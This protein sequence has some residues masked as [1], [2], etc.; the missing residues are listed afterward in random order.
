MLC[1]YLFVVKYIFIFRIVATVFAL[2]YILV[3][4]FAKFKKIEVRLLILL[5]LIL[6]L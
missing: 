3:R 2:Y 4:S 6:L 5:I 1:L